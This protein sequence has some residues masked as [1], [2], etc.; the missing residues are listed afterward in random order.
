MKRIGIF[1]SSFNPIHIGHLI[2][3][4]QARIRLNLD[5]IL[6]IPTA[7]PYHK[8]V[9]LLDY[10]IRY[11]MTKKTINDNPFFELSDIEKNLK[12]NSYSYN[13][14]SELIKTENANY[15]FIIGSDSFNNLHTWYEHEKF[16]QLVNLVV[17]KRPGYDINTETLD[18]YRK[19][20]SNEI[21][22]YDD[23][24]IEISSTQIRN[25]I[26]N[27]IIPRYILKDE[28]IEFIQENNLW[29]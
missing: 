20:S 15:Y 17:F 1:G 24:Q 10:D 22:Y 18:R 16:L 14:M 13:I 6:F 23:L 2:I 4:E 29:R 11:E 7:N 28:T 25:S 19:L 5:K 9:D 8:K 26:I 21:I 27:N 3:S 12:I